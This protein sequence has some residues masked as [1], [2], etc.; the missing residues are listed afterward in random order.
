M[1]LPLTMVWSPG[2][3]PPSRASALP[4][5]LLASRAASPTR[6]TERSALA[7]GTLRE[8]SCEPPHGPHASPSASLGGGC[9]P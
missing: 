2:P 5:V 8:R 7:R 3:T 6:T 9:G 1:H 4:R